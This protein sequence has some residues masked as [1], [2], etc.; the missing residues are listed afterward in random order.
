MRLSCALC[1]SNDVMI[2]LAPLRLWFLI[3]VCCRIQLVPAHFM[4]IEF[5]NGTVG[6]VAMNMCTDSFTQ[7]ILI[8]FA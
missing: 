4:E 3:Q 7:D 8:Q 2:V 6:A 1:G 5:T